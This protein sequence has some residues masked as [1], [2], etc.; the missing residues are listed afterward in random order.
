MNDKL[1]KIYLNDHLAGSMAGLELAKRCCSSNEGT[2]LGDY[3]EQ[4]VTEIETD[5]S[6]L[7]NLMDSL[8]AAKDPVKQLAAWA[9][10]KLGR[11]KMNGQL[12]GYSDLSRL[13]ELE[14]LSLGVEGKLSL[15]RSLKNV[16][17]HDS[18]LATADLD[19]LVARAQE[20]R[21]ELK[22]HHLEAGAKALAG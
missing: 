9:G 18:R 19:R 8:G 5:K 4:L 21:E 20:Q 12:T 22:L 17:D 6:E 3:L 16:A 11:L 13:E 15:W 7:E 14:G 1:L 10:E 2:P